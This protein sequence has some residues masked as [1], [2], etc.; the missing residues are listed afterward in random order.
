MI[1]RSANTWE[2]WQRA[3]DRALVSLHEAWGHSLANL[4]AAV[5]L[6]TSAIRWRGKA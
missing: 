4:W 1:Q 2:A 3:G 5:A 6:E